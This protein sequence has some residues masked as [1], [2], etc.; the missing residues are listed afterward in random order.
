MVF[1]VLFIFIL[2]LYSIWTVWER[3]LIANCHRRKGPNVF[4]FWGV[5]QLFADGFKLISNDI[6]VGAMREHFIITAF[7]TFIFGFVAL[8]CLIYAIVYII[9]LFLWSELFEGYL[10][11]W[12]FFIMH[13]WQ[14]F[15]HWTMILLANF[16]CNR[17]VRFAGWRIFIV[18][19]SI[20]YI[21]ILSGFF[22]LPDWYS[23]HYLVFIM[24]LGNLSYLFDNRWIEKPFLLIV[25][26]FICI[27]ESNRIPVDLIEAENEIVE[28]INVELAALAYGFFASIEYIFLLFNI[29]F[30]SLNFVDYRFCYEL[31][32]ALC[33]LRATKAR[34]RY[35]DLIHLAIYRIFPVAFN[36][37]IFYSFF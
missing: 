1:L 23:S 2:L 25:L 34:I 19:V 32:A 6:L 3:V 24:V 11:L 37:A 35:F 33:I 5:F 13:L 22:I 14:A 26:L 15:E 30:I 17:Y 4:G 27:I 36:A 20:D 29:L 12:S 16:T 21:A 10:V 18:I 7:S 8:I 28:G 9:L 31:F